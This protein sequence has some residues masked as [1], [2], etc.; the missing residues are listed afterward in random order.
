MNIETGFM[1][2][3]MVREKYSEFLTKAINWYIVSQNEASFHKNFPF[4]L[5]NIFQR[6]YLF[7]I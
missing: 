4:E 6:Y 2:S 1:R 3:K 5:K 7:A